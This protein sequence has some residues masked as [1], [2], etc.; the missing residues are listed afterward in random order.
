[1]TAYAP[2]R[3]VCDRCRERGCRIGPAQVVTC[4]RHEHKDRNAPA[5]SKGTWFGCG[6]TGVVLTTET[7]VPV[8]CPNCFGTGRIRCRCLDCHP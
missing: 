2:P 4:A 5:G 3:E 6:G 8:P 1:M 7:R